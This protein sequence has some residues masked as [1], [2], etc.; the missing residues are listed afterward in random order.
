[1]T[2][3]MFWRDRY[4]ALLNAFDKDDT[5]AQFVR[6]DGQGGFA[7]G[8]Y[9]MAREIDRLRAKCGEPNERPKG[10]EAR[11]DMM[12]DAVVDAKLNIQH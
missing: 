6:E 3:E 2:D 7:S 12:A 11:E 10:W 5:A 4:L 9:R 1:M 8:V